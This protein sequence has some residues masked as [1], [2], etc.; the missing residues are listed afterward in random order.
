MWAVVTVVV[1]FEL[2][3]ATILA[4]T[5]GLGAY[6]LAVLY[7]EKTA[8]VTF[9]WAGDDLHKLVATNIEKL[10]LLLGGFGAE[11]FRIS[12]E[13]ERERES[14]KASLQGYK[15]ILNSKNTEESLEPGH[16]EFRLRH[17]W[18][19]YLMIGSLTR[20][21][22]CRIETINDYLSYEIQ[23]SCTKIEL[24]IR[25]SFIELAV[26]IKTMTAP[27]SHYLHIIKS[28]NAAKNLKSLLNTSLCKDIQLLEIVP[29]ATVVCLLMDVV[30]CTEKIADS[31]LE[32]ASLARFESG[33]HQLEQE[34]P[35]SPNQEAPQG[36]NSIGVSHKVI[37]VE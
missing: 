28:K 15:S 30:S 12:G 27:S 7:G 29:V 37:T 3:V 25:K 10:G 14:K 11:F 18:K 31:V 34:K 32:L 23:E 4:A 20:Q 6:R 24:R 33:E 19:Q 13:R 1:D 9:L 36:C 35:K 5:P 17:P 21:R 16:G 8:K 26:A 2:S 22:A